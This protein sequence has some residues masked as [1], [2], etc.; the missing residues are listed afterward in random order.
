MSTE[1]PSAG[2][3]HVSPYSTREKIGRLL[4]SIVQ[5][6]LFRLSFPTWYGWRRF[7]LRRFGARID[8]TAHVRRTAR[9]ECPWNL[10]MERNSCLGDHAIAYCLAR[11]DFLQGLFEGQARVHQRRQL[12]RHQGEFSRLDSPRYSRL[13]LRHIFDDV[14][15]RHYQQHGI[16]VAVEEDP[17]H[18]L[19][20]AARLPFAP[21]FVATAG[22]K[23]HLPRL[24]RSF[25]AFGIH[26]ADQA[27][28]PQ[29]HPV[30][31][32]RGQR[33]RPTRPFAPG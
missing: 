13:K 26:V 27:D 7:L 10:R 9:I 11:P 29:E 4:W 6:T 18:A 21:E 19:R 1:S 5:A 8:A 2:D 3:R 12:S 24:D 15:R 28:R 32:E 25:Q 16:A 22:V 33:T 17:L 31:A 14:V 23:V 20:V 30:A